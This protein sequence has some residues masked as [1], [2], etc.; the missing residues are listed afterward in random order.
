VKQLV[1][2]LKRADG[3]LSEQDIADVC[4]SFQAA[5]GEAVADRA[6]HA[7]AAFRHIVPAG[8]ALVIAG[9]VAANKDLRARLARL[10]EETDIRMVAPPLRLCT[11]NGAMIAW[12]G[13]ERLRLGLTDALDF[14]PRPR[15]P[16][17]PEAP[18]AAFAGVKA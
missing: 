8:G 5:A 10:A 4:A 6:A 13:I 1:D 17:D 18:P 7:I 16:L 11:D 14:R 3:P 9:G 12:A 15:W 2:G